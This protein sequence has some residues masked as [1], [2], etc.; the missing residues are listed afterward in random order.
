MKT[1]IG[2]LGGAFD[3]PTLG[4]LDLAD[5]LINNQI[6]DEVWLEPCYKSYYDKNMR[7]PEVR[8]EM[9]QRA[10]EDFGNIDI[11]VCDFEI[12][13]KVEGETNEGIDLFFQQYGTSDR[14]FLFMIGMDNANKIHTWGGWEELVN[15]IPFI[16]FPRNGYHFDNTKTWYLTTPHIFIDQYVPIDISSTVIRNFYKDRKGNE[17]HDKIT[18]SVKKMI[19]TM[20]LYKL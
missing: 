2:L 15:K 13:N 20:Q 8:L 16:I 4:H 12:T 11:K 18:D 1:R 19:D 3:P 17:H 5:Y 10:I 6:V 9:C 7:S 14:K